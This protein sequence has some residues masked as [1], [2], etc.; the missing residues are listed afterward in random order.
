MQEVHANCRRKI[1][2]KI[3]GAGFKL[4]GA[5]RVRSSMS[6]LVTTILFLRAGAM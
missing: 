2:G 5:Q 3:T 4:A 1:L 6:S